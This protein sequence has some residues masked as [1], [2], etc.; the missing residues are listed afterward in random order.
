MGDKISKLKQEMIEVYGLKCWLNELW[1]PKRG[2]LITYHHIIEKR[3]GGKA[4]WKNGAL[5]GRTSHDFLNKIDYT[6]HKIYNELNWLFFELNRTLMP[7]TEEYYEEV[8]RVL[9]KGGY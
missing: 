2:N 8:K 4:I 9:K 3:N 1:I 7:P 6:N 5:L